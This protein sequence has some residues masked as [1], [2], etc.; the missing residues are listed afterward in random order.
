[1]DGQSREGAVQAATAGEQLRAAGRLREG[2]MLF[3][4]DAGEG[5]RVSRPKLLKHD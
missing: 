4:A 5:P 2:R 1:V 3:A